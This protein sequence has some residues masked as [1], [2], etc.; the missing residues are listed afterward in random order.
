MKPLATFRVYPEPH[1]RFHA[2]VRVYATKREMQAAIRADTRQV[3]EDTAALV[4]PVEVLSF[5]T[6]RQ[7]TLPIFAEVYLAATRLGTEVLCHESV[8]VADAYLRRRGTPVTLG[9]LNGT[10]NMDETIA[11][12]TGR[13]ARLLVTRLRAFK[14]L[15]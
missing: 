6:G 2:K 1:S 8:H 15:P 4:G 3:S 14:L 5:K 12:L 7:R 13:I 9:E 11:T 10:G